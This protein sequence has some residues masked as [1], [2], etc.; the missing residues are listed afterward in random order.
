[1]TAIRE[2][3]V[4]RA[5]RA[6]TLDVVDTVRA[7]CHDLRQPLAAVLLLAQTPLRGTGEARRRMELI[8]DQA[9]WIATLV[10][11]VLLEAP[12]QDVV[13]VDVAACAASAAARAGAT[14]AQPIA[15]S[16][17]GSAMAWAREVALTR[18]LGC[19]LDNA[20]RAAGPGRVAVDVIGSG[21]EVEVL[22]TDSGPGLGG[23]P[24]QTSLGLA[25]T[26]ALVATC[27]GSFTLRN[28]PSGG[29]VARVALSAVEI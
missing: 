26:R 24:A 4:P 15:V 17:S 6:S 29:A 18:A 22:I 19:L 28:Q 8:A 27:G 20:V 3:P 10:D 12:G 5:P 7:L 16:V 21:G 14:A 25:I 9:A 1:M 13:P 2:H 23:V 11:Q